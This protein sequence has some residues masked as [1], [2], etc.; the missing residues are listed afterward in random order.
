MAT[1]VQADV[2]E[3][4]GLQQEITNLRKKI[5]A[6][7]KRK[8]L[9]ET[10][11]TE[12]LKKTDQGGVKVRETSIIL[13]EKPR[14]ERKKKQDKDKDSLKVLSDFGIKEP[15]KVL[16]KLLNSRKGEKVIS[17]QIKIERKN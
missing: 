4:E 6:L 8:T 11:I 3:Y 15:E 12:Y 9:L 2:K 7:V 14:N 13:K 1:T 17:E 10:R 5:K 16:E